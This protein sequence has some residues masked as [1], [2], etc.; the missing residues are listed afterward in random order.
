MTTGNYSFIKAKAI[1]STKNSYTLNK[2]YPHYDIHLEM[3]D[4]TNYLAAV[5]VYSRV[6]PPSL[7][8]YDFTNLEGALIERVAALPKGI[9]TDLKKDTDGYALD[10]I[11]SGLF[12]I[13]YM[14]ILDPSD[15]VNEKKL[16]ELIDKY[17][18]QAL[19][20]PTIDVAIWGFAFSDKNMQGIH[21][22][23]MNQGNTIPAYKKENGIWQ[24]GGLAFFKEGEKKAFFALFLGFQVQC[25]TTDDEGNCIP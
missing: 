25:F 8:Y 3:P 23:H 14:N 11:R 16:E 22:I 10:Y 17:V 24:D 6:G 5:N 4:G 13:R 15:K 18:Q 2:S 1:R 12:D 9:Y 20:D 19:Q 21:D 7:R